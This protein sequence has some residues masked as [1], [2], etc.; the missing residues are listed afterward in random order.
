M[1]VSIEG[2]FDDYLV[3]D[4]GVYK[5]PL[6]SGR[7]RTAAKW[8][9]LPTG[10]ALLVFTVAV[11]F[12]ARSIVGFVLV[13]L[14]LLAITFNRNLSAM[15]VR[16]GVTAARTQ[17]PPDPAQPGVELASWNDI[18]SA[19]LSSATMVLIGGRSSMRP[20]T[21]EYT[22][23]QGASKSVRLVEEQVEPLTSILRLNLDHRFKVEG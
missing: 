7:L 19:S 15:L 4:E 3:T 5:V 18:V 21:F 16:R 6:V 10:I 13:F 17:S 1:K 12:P 23:A 22:T 11:V 9:P 8:W 14:G 2:D 20:A